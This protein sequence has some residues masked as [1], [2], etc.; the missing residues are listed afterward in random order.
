VA[1]V[2]I[3]QV[4]ID[5]ADDEEFNRWYDEEHVPEKLHT[6]GFVSARRFRSFDQAAS[7]LVI[8]ELENP[9]AATNKS[10]MRTEP[11]EWSKSVMARWKNWNRAVW[12]QLGSDQ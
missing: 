2:L 4:E 7:Y 3:V 5:P 6:P 12:V 11:T 10:Y 8:Y 1:A 9:Q